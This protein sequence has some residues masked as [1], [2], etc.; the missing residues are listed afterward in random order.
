MSSTA[1]VTID[2]C[3]TIATGLVSWWKGEN[4]TGDLL[5]ANMG[6]ATGG[7][8]FVPGQVGQAFS[9]NGSNSY[10]RVP[11]S[12]N[13]NVA[14]TGQG[15]SFEAWISPA[16]LRTS[17]I[18]EWNDGTNIVNGGVEFWHSQPGDSGQ[19]P[20]CLFV[21]LDASCYC[22]FLSSAP[23]LVTN[24][25]QHV[26]FTYDKAS[27][28]LKL[29]YNGA[30]VARRTI[31]RSVRTDYDL[32]IGARDFGGSMYRYYFRGGIDEPSLYNRALSSNEIAA[33][34][35]MGR[36]GKCE[37]EH[38][39][40]I[41]REPQ[42]Q[43]VVAGRNANL[44][45]GASG[46]GPLT[47]QWQCNGV[48]LTN[49]TRLSGA[50]ASTLFIQDLVSSDSGIYTVTVSNPYG[51]VRSSNVILTVINPPAVVMTA[52]ADGSTA[53]APAEIGLSAEVLDLEALA[54]SVRFY[55]LSNDQPVWMVWLPI[56]VRACFQPT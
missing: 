27:G 9:L 31:L 5:D 17:P 48:D 37:P 13:A 56:L 15:I 23:V 39:P 47:F 8:S 41:W 18:M 19:G 54:T 50:A 3:E 4:D 1:V 46:P 33:I 26:A 7:L 14:A 6:I 35:V 51:S 2:Y 21:N 36:S 40:V 10:I 11:A 30:V 29:Y 38:A 24:R 55:A 52:P 25:F 49:S 22:A 28:D 32:Y 45:I 20:G 44:S 12:S 53:E 34:Y 43:T 42:S 16:D